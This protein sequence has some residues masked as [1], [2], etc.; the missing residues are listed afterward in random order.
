[1][2]KRVRKYETSGCTQDSMCGAL[3]AGKGHEA[4]LIA[5]IHYLTTICAD[6][7]LTWIY[8]IPSLG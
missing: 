4:K 7:T 8:E 2:M 5:I 3:S 1:M 6:L